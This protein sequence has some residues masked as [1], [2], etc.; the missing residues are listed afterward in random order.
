VKGCKGSPLALQLIAVSLC[1]LPFEMWQK[2]KECL[3][4]QTIYDCI[5]QPNFETHVL[6]GELTSHQSEWELDEQRQIIEACTDWWKQ[7]GIIS[8]MYSFD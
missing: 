2:M 1:E 3:N 4:G 8:R 6:N 5:E 7:Q